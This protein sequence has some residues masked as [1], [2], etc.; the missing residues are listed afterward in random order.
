MSSNY[1]IAHKPSLGGTHAVDSQWIMDLLTRSVYDITGHRCRR[2]L[3]LEHPY[4]RI[5]LL[6]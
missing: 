2:R 3:G 5:A 1:I 4:N 6:T